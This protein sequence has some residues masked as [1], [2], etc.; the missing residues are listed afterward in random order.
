M[1]FI[2]LSKYLKF[3]LGSRVDTEIIYLLRSRS[4]FFKYSTET[5]FKH[6]AN[7]EEIFSP[8]LKTGSVVT[9][10]NSFFTVSDMVIIASECFNET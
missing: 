5:L 8:Q 4:N 9:S 10:N 7:S 2:T 1:G 6:S 3:F